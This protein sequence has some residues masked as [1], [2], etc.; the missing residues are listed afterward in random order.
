MKLSRRGFLKTSA[1]TAAGLVV[2][3]GLFAY[4]RP[5]TEQNTGLGVIRNRISGTS[6]DGS[7]VRFI[8]IDGGNYGSVYE[9]V[10]A[11][12]GYL[13]DGL[14]PGHYRVEVDDQQGGAVHI[15]HVTE[16]LY[17]DGRSPYISVLARG[18]AAILVDDN[19]VDGEVNDEF[20]GFFNTFSRG[21]ESTGGGRLNRWDIERNPPRKI[22][23]VRGDIGESA[24]NRFMHMVEHV[25]GNSPQFFGGKVPYLSIEHAEQ[26]PQQPPNGVICFAPYTFVDSQTEG[27]VGSCGNWMRGDAITASAIHISR[28]VLYMD[29]PQDFYNDMG[30]H[31]FGH[32]AGEHHTDPEKPGIMNPYLEM[33]AV[34]PDNIL[35][36]YGMYDKGMWIGNVQPDTNKSGVS[37]QSVTNHVVVCGGHRH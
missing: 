29:K 3:S 35:G 18:P 26:E 1:A 4:D 27:I 9:Q 25:N 30:M 31:E 14:R 6:L 19:Y 33:F 10:A 28:E 11:A 5:E 23:A 32:A 12:G 7:L 16:S 13:L 36:M 21:D 22:L 34:L 8:G 24:Y 37:S 20:L 2:P 15:P 17:F